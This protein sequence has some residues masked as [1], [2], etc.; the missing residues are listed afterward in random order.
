MLN[1]LKYSILYYLWVK[2]NQ[3]I[4]DLIMMN[5]SSNIGLKINYLA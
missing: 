4:N 1:E 2:Q 5:L 3:D